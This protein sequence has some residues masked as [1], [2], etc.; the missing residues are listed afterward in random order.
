MQ[1]EQILAGIIECIGTYVDSFFVQL[2]QR[3]RMNWGEFADLHKLVLYSI[4]VPS[5]TEVH[6]P[7]IGVSYYLNFF[8]RR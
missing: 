2:N 3:F 7:A 8:F 6:T 5:K 1:G 4:S